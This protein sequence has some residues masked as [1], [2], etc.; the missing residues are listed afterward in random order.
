MLKFHTNDTTLLT[1]FED[2][3]TTVFV[4]IDDLY[5][6]Y[7]PPEV[8]KRRHVLDAK[9]SDSEIITVSLCGELVGIDSEN[10]WYSFVKRNYQ[11]L[12]PNLCSKSCFNRTRRALLQ[13]MELLRQK[14]FSVFAVS[15]GRFFIV[16]SFPPAVCKFG[17]ARYCHTFRGL[18]PDYGKCPS[19]KETYFGY[20][21]HAMVTLEGYVTAFEVTPAST[22][23]REGLR[24]LVDGQSGLVLLGDKGYT[25]ETLVE[26]LSRQ[27]IC[28]MALK[29][30]NSRTDWPRHVRQ[31]IFRLRRRVEMVFSQLSGQL[32]AERVLARSFQGLCMRLANKILAYNL[33]MVLNSLFGKDWELA[34]IKKFV[35]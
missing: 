28:L 11:H 31:L 5:R 8:T 9:L 12:F 3:I 6:H 7:A 30:S 1:T 26:G 20:K 17:R 33:C 35:F 27:G 15:S 24:D 23:D 25:S 4:I 32:N 19:K 34:R 13:T 10:A 21:V 16:D 22:D 14:L 29:C 2:F 18:G